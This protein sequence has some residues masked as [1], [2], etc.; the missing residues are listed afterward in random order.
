MNKDTRSGRR[1]LAVGVPEYR[2]HI[3]CAGVMHRFRHI[4]REIM[5]G[6][7]SLSAEEV[8]PPVAPGY[9]LQ[10]KVSSSIY[11][12]YSDLLCKIE[13]AMACKHLTWPA[14][15]THDLLAGTLQGVISDGGLVIDG[16]LLNFD[17]FVRLLST[18]EGFP[19][20]LSVGRWDE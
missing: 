9:R 4:P 11:T 2:D 10:S 14:D 15:G 7:W 12:A 3:D 5:E 6:A 18:H 16:R 19:I 8:N 1:M 13:D 20:K 17:E